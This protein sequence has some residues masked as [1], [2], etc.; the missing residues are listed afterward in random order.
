MKLESLGAM[1][2]RSGN[3]LL[4]ALPS[5][6]YAQL[7]G[8]LR[9][10]ALSTGACIQQ[11]Y[12]PVCDVWFPLDCLIS[13][14]AEISPGGVLEVGLVGSAGVVGI[15]GRRDGSGSI[16]SA[17]V[18]NSG[19]ALCIAVQIL[20]RQLPTCPN[21]QQVLYSSMHGLLMEASQNAVCSHY[22]LLEA[23]LARSL[24]ATR[25]ALQTSEFHLT[26]EFLGQALGVR[27]VGVTKAATALQTRNLIRYTRGAI[28]VID[29]PGLEQAACACYA[30]GLVQLR[31][32]T[33]ERLIK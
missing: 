14:R 1:P 2:N 20:E 6:E 5:A 32:A 4:A 18:Q 27:R 10:V 12:Q 25:D 8:A 11:A 17:I 21:L 7:D 23:R 3:R 19:T 33:K 28:T 26:H 15:A 9:S 24:L 22:H 29:G 16:L 13:V 31:P 30:L